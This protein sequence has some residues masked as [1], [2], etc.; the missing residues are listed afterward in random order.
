MKLDA[1]VEA[2]FRSKGVCSLEWSGLDHINEH[3]PYIKWA[4]TCT[5]LSLIAESS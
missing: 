4:T 3:R 1:I 5:P 2:W